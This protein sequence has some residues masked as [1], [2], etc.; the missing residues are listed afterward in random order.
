MNRILTVVAGCLILCAGTVPAA[1]PVLGG[2]SPRGAQRGTDAV[3]TFGGARLEDAKEVVF[4]TPGFTVTKLEP[5]AGAVKATVKIAA[6]CQLGEHAVRVRTATGLTEMRTVWVGALP[7]I[8]EKEPNS[9]FTTPQKVGLNVTVEG[10]VDNEDVDYY[11]VDL[12]K[13]QRLSAEVEAMR[14]ANTLFDPY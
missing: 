9:E 4:Y 2:V 6:D 12:K 1:S 14:L 5:A 13:G 7:A 8:A 10:V 11:A 3:F